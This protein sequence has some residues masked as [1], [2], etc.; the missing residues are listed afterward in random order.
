MRKRWLIGGVAV[1][2]VLV[3]AGVAWKGGKGGADAT[4]TRRRDNDG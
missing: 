1:V 3:G 4:I 2:I